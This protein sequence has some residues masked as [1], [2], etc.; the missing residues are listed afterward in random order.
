MFVL[1]FIVTSLFSNF[2]TRYTIHFHCHK[3]RNSILSTNIA[4]LPTSNRFIAF[5]M[6][7]IVKHV[8]IDF[9]LSFIGTYT[10]CY[11]VFM[12]KLAVCLS[13]GVKSYFCNI[14]LRE[15]SFH[16]SINQLQSV[17]FSIK[18]A[19]LFGKSVTYMY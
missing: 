17:L 13:D 4:M 5:P 19:G 15:K 3:L 9:R 7:A 12:T 11:T 18:E 10:V 16:Y 2:D 8:V 1:K 14:N 6:H